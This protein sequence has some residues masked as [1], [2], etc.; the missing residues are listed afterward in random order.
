MKSCPFPT[1]IDAGGLGDL[2]LP[3]SKLTVTLMILALNLWEVLLTAIL[4]LRLEEV[5]TSCPHQSLKDSAL[6][7]EKL[8]CTIQR[9]IC[10]ISLKWYYLGPLNLY[11]FTTL[12][13]VLSLWTPAHS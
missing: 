11:V 7:D 13:P 12:L 4:V 2:V 9:S 3:R 6:F 5:T 8:L 1:G 10:S